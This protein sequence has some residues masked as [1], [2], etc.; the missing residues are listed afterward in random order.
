MAT[1]ARAKV[2]S[3]KTDIQTVAAAVQQF[4]VNQGTLPTTLQELVAGEFVSKPSDIQDAWGND[5][6]FQAPAQFAGQQVDWMLISLGE[7]GTF[8]GEAPG[9]DD[10]I[11]A[12]GHDVFAP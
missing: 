11:L 4:Q 10:I 8:E 3:T 7:N 12:E 5:F 9:S 6:F 2:S 1:L